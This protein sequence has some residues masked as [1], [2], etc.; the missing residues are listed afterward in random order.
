MENVISVN[1]S[2][3]PGTLCISGIY[4]DTPQKHPFI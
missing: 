4:T 3:R 1:N 2:E